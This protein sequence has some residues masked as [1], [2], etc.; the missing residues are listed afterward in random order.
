MRQE[1]LDSQTLK[2]CDITAAT[3]ALF[4]QMVNASKAAASWQAES[5]L[6]QDH[7]QNTVASWTHSQG[8]RPFDPANTLGKRQNGISHWLVSISRSDPAG[9]HQG[10]PYTMPLLNTTQSMPHSPCPGT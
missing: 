9:A 1:L 3:S 2:K 4:F 10:P 5:Q 7:V 6:C 8:S